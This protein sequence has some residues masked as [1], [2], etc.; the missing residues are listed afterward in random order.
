MIEAKTGVSKNELA[1]HI[2]DL[3]IKPST[4]NNAWLL[5]EQEV[6]ELMNYILIKYQLKKLRYLTD[7]IIITNA[8]RGEDDTETAKYILL[9]NYK[10]KIE[11][12]EAGLDEDRDGIICRHKGRSV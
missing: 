12:I 2:R 1:Y 4:W 8:L 7:Q 9:N 3:N 11:S 6:L 10:E 5:Q